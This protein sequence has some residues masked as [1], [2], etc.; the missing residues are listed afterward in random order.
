MLNILPIRKGINIPLDTSVIR[1]GVGTHQDI[2]FLMG[3]I[4]APTDDAISTN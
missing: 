3:A 2:N 4:I 1:R